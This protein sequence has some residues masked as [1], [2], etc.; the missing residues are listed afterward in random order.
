[1]ELLSK[2]KSMIFSY[3][4]AHFF[5]DFACAFLMFSSVANDSTWYLSVLLYNFCAFALQMPFG[6]LA[7]AYNRN[8]R[9]ALGGIVLI[10]A[11]FGSTGLPLA[12]AIVAGL[13]NGLFHVGGGIDVLNISQ[14]KSSP[15]GIFVSPGA[16]GLYLGTIQGKLGNLS[17]FWPL[18][19]LAFSALLILLASKLFKGGYPSNSPFSLQRASLSYGLIAAVSLFLV[20][21]LRSYVGLTLQFPWKGR[22]YWGLTLISSVVLGKVAGG[23]AADRFGMLKTSVF[24]MLGAA[25]LFLLPNVPMAGV[26]SIF[27]FN[28]SMPITLWVMAKIYPGAKGFTFGLLTFGLF[29]GYIPQY[30]GLPVPTAPLS[31]ALMAVVSLLLLYGGISGAKL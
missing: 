7:D 23:F 21:C 28:M 20:V 3:S 9:F 30:L 14:N 29:I 27:L 31:F 13:G 25:L 24:S 17:F 4:T 8:S 6:A 15:L 19:F 18:V 11:A 16:L 26:L 2:Y 22:G 5:V 1:M 10:A 12:A